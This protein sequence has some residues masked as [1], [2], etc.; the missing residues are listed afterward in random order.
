[1][2]VAMGLG[3]VAVI[4]S[5]RAGSFGM[6]LVS[7]LVLFALTGIGNGTTYRMIPAIFRSQSADPVAARRS[8]AAALGIVSAVGA[9]G[10]FLV[11]RS[12]GLSIERT[13]G[14]EAA[15][16]GFV[17]FY[18]VCTAVTWWCYLRSRVLVARVPSLAHAG[19]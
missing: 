12:F 10:G 5:V 18:A 19:V 4:A 7:F 17:A 9:Y 8:S 3:V 6:F 11:P 1:V 13:G 14:I 15:L 2:F 16:I